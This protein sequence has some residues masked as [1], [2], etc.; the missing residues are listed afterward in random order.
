MN[1]KMASAKQSAYRFF[2]KHAWFSYDPTTETQ[3][4]GRAKC[5]RLLAKAEINAKQLGF[6]YIWEDDYDDYDNSLGDHAVWCDDEK[7]GI[8]HSHEVY[9]CIM[10]D[11]DGNAVDS[12]G[13]IIEPSREG[14]RVIEAELALAVI[15]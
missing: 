5:A 13:A 9:M 4:Q 3:Q 15:G 12:L 14:R 2:Y 7:H 6:T 11:A 1:T 8:E 10:E